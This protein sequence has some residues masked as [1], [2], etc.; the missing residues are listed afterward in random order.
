[1]TRRALWSSL[2]AGSILSL[3]V[4]I[5]IGTQ[6][7]VLG[8]G[9]GNWV[10]PYIQPFHARTLAVFALVCAIALPLC[11]V[12]ARFADRH[13]CWMVA[14]WLLVGFGSQALSAGWWRRGSSLASARRRSF[15][16]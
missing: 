2:L 12:P 10:Y 7:I 14:A 8:S 15:A 6:S 13:I 11:A 5:G 9:A 4:A 1:M 3:L 16:H